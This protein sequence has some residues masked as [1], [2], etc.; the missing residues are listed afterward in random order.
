MTNSNETTTIMIYK[1]T[2]KALE[3]RKVH[4]NQSYDEVIQGL[5]KKAKEKEA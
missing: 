5:L 4:R 3:E 1:T 2:Q